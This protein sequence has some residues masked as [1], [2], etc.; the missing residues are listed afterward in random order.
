MTQ[1]IVNGGSR[2][3]QDLYVG[4]QNEVTADESNQELRLHDGA[5]PGGHRIPNIDTVDARYQKRNA[6]LDGFKFD[7][8]I[9]GFLTRIA[10][11]VYRLRKFV[12]DG[13][14][15]LS[16]ADGVGG[17]PTFGLAETL[18]GDRKFVGDVIVTGVAEIDGGVN[19]DTAGTHTGPTN[20]T[21]TGP[22]VGDVDLRGHTLQLDGNQIP[23]AA[24]AGL[25]AALAALVTPVGMVSMWSGGLDKIPAGWALCNGNNGTPDLRNRFV[26]GAAVQT[27]VDATGGAAT[28]THVATVDPSGDHS[29]AITVDPFQ[30][31]IQHMPAHSHA[32]GVCDNG[33]ALFNHG[34]VAA[35]PSTQNSIADNP[36]RGIN[37]GA[38][39]VSGGG[40]PH[41]HTGSS[42]TA[43]NHTHAVTVNPA[44]ILPPY[45]MLAYIMRIN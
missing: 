26:L 2:S 3:S 37:E 29:H 36:D 1:T 13:N 44:T 14:I 35:N 45:Y 32:N 19:A 41:N 38:T 40:A 12:T 17:N 8:N 34:V 42:A 24:V 27:D 39:N 10:T 23:Q 21:H 5:T 43:G 22:T 30:L 11:G 20:G 9:K 28:H 25:A 15:T 18:N 4:P 16:N 31:L 7:P 33:S 6:E